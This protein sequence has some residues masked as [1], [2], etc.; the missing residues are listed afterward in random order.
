MLVSA[1]IAFGPPRRIVELARAGAIDLVV[2]DVVI[3]ELIRVLV[4]HG[5]ERT[6]LLEYATTLDALAAQRSE[7][8]LDPEPVTGD[9]DDD[10]ILACAIANR[11]DA[12]VSG[13]RRHL[14]PLGRQ[15]G[16][17][18]LSPEALV[19]ELRSRAE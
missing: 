16:T 18:I 5:W 10:R 15:R 12:L 14:L 3:E 1:A 19:A 8:P 4:R 13:N 7:A 2:V 11:V 6:R 9:P 17:R